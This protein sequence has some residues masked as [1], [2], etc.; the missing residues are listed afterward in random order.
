M[1]E[2]MCLFAYILVFIHMILTK[3]NVFGNIIKTSSHCRD[4]KISSKVRVT[5]FPSFSIYFSMH[6]QY[7]RIAISIHLLAIFSCAAHLY[8]D[9]FYGHITFNNFIRTNAGKFYY[10]F[11]LR[12]SDLPLNESETTITTIFFTLFFLIVKICLRLTS[13][14]IELSFYIGAISVGLIVKNFLN[15][16][17]HNQ[18]LS[19][20]KVC[21]VTYL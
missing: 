6:F 18:N 15:V 1:A 3:Q 19:I 17:S 10:G 12:D 16:L 13:H 2:G 8:A 5:R 9:T 14:F 7:Q 4:S 11:H 20:A 21:S